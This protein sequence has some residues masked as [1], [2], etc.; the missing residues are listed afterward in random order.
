MTVSLLQGA[1][2]ALKE[3]SLSDDQSLTRIQQNLLA[4]QERRLLNWLCARLPQW[5]TP[6]LLTLLALFASVVIF[7]GY[8]LS[9]TSRGW[10]WLSVAGYFIHWFGDSLDGSI[11]R[12]RSIERP[13]YGYFVDHSA[14]VMGALF[15]VGGIG[16]TPFVRLDVALIALA[17]Y[18]MLAAHAFLAARVVSELNLTYIA[19]GPTELR[20]IL[21]GLTIA[22]YIFG[23]AGPRLGNLGVFDLFAGA[24]A[25]ILIL[26]FVV[27]TLAM[28]RRLAREGEQKV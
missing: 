11:A 13:R 6:D 19:A 16:L 20:L 8:A 27:Q 25:V 28:A 14:D 9:G 4:R 23:D 22:M 26:L 15:I 5:V 18:Y 17:G 10:L 7:A 3:P 24:V 21:I 1:R 12:Y 2:A